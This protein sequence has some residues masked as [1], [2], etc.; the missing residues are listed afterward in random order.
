[1]TYGKYD[2]L[3]SYS[4]VAYSSGLHLCDVLL[5]YPHHEEAGRPSIRKAGGTYS[6]LAG[7]SESLT[8][9]GT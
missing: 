4:P 6:S 5:S 7:T 1:M 2:G 9:G 3:V 8:R